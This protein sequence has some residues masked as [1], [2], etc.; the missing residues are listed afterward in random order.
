MTNR[1]NLENK[2]SGK[3]TQNKSNK[4]INDW[5]KKFEKYFKT[6]TFN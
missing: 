2:K 5:Y 6:L 1:L 4:A 3:W